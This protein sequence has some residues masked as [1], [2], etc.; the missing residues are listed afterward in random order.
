MATL[1]NLNWLDSWNWI[2]KECRPESGKSLLLVTE[3][4]KGHCEPLSW[5]SI[6]WSQMAKLFGNAK[7]QWWT[8]AAWRSLKSVGIYPVK[9][10]KV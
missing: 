7:S 1:K 6:A 9:W 8:L 3:G 2:S 4:S 10:T 5:V